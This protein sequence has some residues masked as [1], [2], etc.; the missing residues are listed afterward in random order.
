MSIGGTVLHEPVIRIRPGAEV[1]ISGT[2]GGLSHRISPAP[3]AAR[4]IAEISGRASQGNSAPWHW[5]GSFP[6]QQPFR[7]ELQEYEFLLSHSWFPEG[8]Y[9]L[10]LRLTTENA[11]VEDSAELRRTFHIS[12]AVDRWLQNCGFDLQRL[13]LHSGFLSL[14]A[15]LCPEFSGG[16]PEDMSVLQLGGRFRSS[17]SA[18][19]QSFAVG[20]FSTVTAPEN[21]LGTAFEVVFPFAL[22]CAPT[23]FL[24]LW[25]ETSDPAAR[26]LVRGISSTCSF[27]S[28][29]DG[30]IPL[31]DCEVTMQP[32]RQRQDIFVE[33]SGCVKNTG[34]LVWQNEQYHRRNPYRIALQLLS[35][36]QAGPVWEQRYS[37][38]EPLVFPGDSAHF[39]TA[40]ETLSL[41]A[42]SYQLQADILRE[43]LF[44]FS[45]R[46]GTKRCSMP[47]VHAPLQRA[48]VYSDRPRIPGGDD[49][50]RMSLLVLAPELPLFDRSAGGKRLLSILRILREAGCF[51][52]FLYDHLPPPTED[53]RYT[54][55]LDALGV[56][57]AHGTAQALSGLTAASF[58]AALIAWWQQ[59]ERFLPVLRE[60]NPEAR[61]VV[62]S[63]DLHWVREERGVR[64][65]AL[66]YSTSELRERKAGERAVYEKADT[67]WVVTEEDRQ[68]LLG[69]LPAA[70]T[71]VISMI[72]EAKEIRCP[73]RPRAMLFVGSFRHPPNEAA[74]LW[75]IEIARAFK[76]RDGSGLPLFIAG[77]APSP[78][79][80][81]EHDGCDI[82]L[83]GYVE[84]LD[85]LYAECSLLLAPLTYGG[86]I[87]GKIS[88][89]LAHGLTVLTTE[90]GNEG[91]G[92]LDKEEGFLCRN[93]EEFVTTLSNICAGAFDLRGI[94]ENGQNKVRRRFGRAAARAGIG[95][96]FRCPP[97][98]IAIVTYNAE[99][100]LR[101]SLDSLLARTSY[102]RMRIAVYSNGC[103]DGTIP[104]LREL[105][106]RHD[107][108]IDIYAGRTNEFFVTPNNLLAQSYPDAD[109]LLLN[110]DVEILSSDW[111]WQLADAAYSSPDIAA[112]GGLL[113]DSEGR[114][115]EAGAV[116]Q[117]D[118]SGRN[119]GRGLPETAAPAGPY[120]VGYCSGC[121]LYMKRESLKRVGLLDPLFAPMYYEDVDWQFRAHLLGLKTV[122]TPNA[123][124]RHHEG[125][126]AGT[127]PER[128]MKR[129]QEINREKF[130]HKFS[131]IDLT[132]LNS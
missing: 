1:L 54:A 36:Q 74:A 33:I 65:G 67:V 96:S 35:D 72:E 113:L 111:L 126:S 12:R 87:K 42:G 19:W 94:A 49:L 14:R 3:A 2:V 38:A 55:A 76:A 88:E 107:T 120:F 109:I 15:A 5:R 90:V 73:A 43:Q 98:V 91:I 78:A 99:N 128:G 60:L 66:M 7:G 77:D 30:D 63:V 29:K 117:A 97:V 79:L 11:A 106:R 61:C 22:P 82:H 10:R 108:P 93:T 123:R 83:L 4:V 21:S 13:S 115:S 122:F 47:F 52:L 50:G 53:G 23:C 125:S 127:D 84:N 9:E 31:Y 32:L 100:L 24:E 86:G 58:Q 129:F 103:S 40:F 26:R 132:A 64:A 81:A 71:R 89:A 34:A 28:E 46:T 41:T 39:T 62:D 68:A 59:A 51:I 118:G 27:S 110:N 20:I 121:L 25:L 112:A 119:L 130:L 69:E 56:R 116:L 17:A 102:P 37:F 44:W 48:T 16:A 45:N 124:V 131:G 80:L 95:T 104:Y 57:H 105:K 85:E 101:C 75:A 92:L 114:I 6:L 8:S 70:S 18:P